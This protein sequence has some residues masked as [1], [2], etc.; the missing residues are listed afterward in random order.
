M[1]TEHGGKDGW[2]VE[3]L[4]YHPNPTRRS[5]TL[6]PEPASSATAAVRVSTA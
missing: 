4:L 2:K 6:S 1:A 5:R 3:T